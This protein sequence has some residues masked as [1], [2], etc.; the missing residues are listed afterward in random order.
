MSAGRFSVIQQVH[1]QEAPTGAAVHVSCPP[2][3]AGNGM[4]QPLW[5]VRPVTQPR[6]QPGPASNI[7]VFYPDDSEIENLNVP[8]DTGWTHTHTACP[9]AALL[10]QSVKRAPVRIPNN[11]VGP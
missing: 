4:K 5:P 3:Q 9:M 7:P 8:A 2:L 10:A 6:T 11:L 1:H